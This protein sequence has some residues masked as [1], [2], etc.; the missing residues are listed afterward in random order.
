MCARAHR[1]HHGSFRIHPQAAS[2]AHELGQLQQQL[3]AAQ[4]EAEGLRSALEEAQ[5][6]HA[7]HLSQ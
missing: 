4:A 6:R 5:Q 3:Q 7:Q 1:K 2:P